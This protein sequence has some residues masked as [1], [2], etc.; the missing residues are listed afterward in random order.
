MA[1]LWKLGNSKTSHISATF[2]N[3]KYVMIFKHMVQTYVFYPCDFLNLK[4]SQ[5][6]SC[7]VFY[8]NENFWNKKEFNFVPIKNIYRNPIQPTKK[9]K[10]EYKIYLKN[11]CVIFRQTCMKIG[12]IFICLWCTLNT[13]FIYY[14]SNVTQFVENT[15]ILPYQ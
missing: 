11:Y 8:Q 12:N 14:N 3:S 15:L 5:P 9:K 6:L 1:P 2:Q 10:K 7:Y 4:N 13:C